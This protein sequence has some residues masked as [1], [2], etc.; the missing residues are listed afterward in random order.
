MNYDNLYMNTDYRC[1]S[2]ILNDEGLSPNKVGWYFHYLLYFSILAALQKRSLS[3]DELSSVA[4]H[5]RNDSTKWGISEETVIDLTREK[6]KFVTENLIKEILKS[7][8]GNLD[9]ISKKDYIRVEYPNGK[10]EIKPNPNYTP[11]NYYA[12]SYSR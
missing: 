4:R 11:T 10:I 1:I 5:L 12:N 3:T 6:L 9:N 8:R 2:A 7:E